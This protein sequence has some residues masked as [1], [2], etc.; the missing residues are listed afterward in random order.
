MQ[1]DCLTPYSQEDVKEMVILAW[2]F[3]EEFDVAVPFG[4][5]CRVTT[6][7][8][9]VKIRPKTEA[10]HA[11]KN[12]SPKTWLKLVQRLARYASAVVSV[13]R[14]KQAV[15]FEL[16]DAPPPYSPLMLCTRLQH[17]CGPSGKCFTTQ[18]PWPAHNHA[19]RTRY[20]IHCEM[21]IVHYFLSAHPN[22]PFPEGFAGSN[23]IGCSKRCCGDCWHFINLHAPF[24]M[25]GVHGRT[26][27]S[28]VL[29]LPMH[30]W[31]ANH[32]VNSGEPG[33]GFKRQVEAQSPILLS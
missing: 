31:L 9:P 29:P 7:Y 15:E 5:D 14:Y 12:R 21:Q 32:P 18:V 30:D 13:A 3:Q 6:K 25:A 2:K 19:L 4:R 33:P 26:Y 22:E 16:L 1:S 27:G 8:G 11:T 20:T 28:W 24:H 23:F 17:H 10:S